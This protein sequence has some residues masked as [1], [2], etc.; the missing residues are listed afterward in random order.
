MEKEDRKQFLMREVE[1]IQAIINRMGHNS[2]LIKGWTITLVVATLLLKGIE[3]QIFIAFI[4]IIIFW[5]LDSYFL[6]QERLYRKLYDW[7]I[8]NRLKTDENLFRM[9]TT[10]FK[11]NVSKPKTIFSLTM[12]WFYGSIL[13]ITIIYTIV[14]YSI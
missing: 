13:G 6:W 5:L 4:P 9:D 12:L 1:T 14:I 8:D 2:F 11:K 3:I 10:P 7:I